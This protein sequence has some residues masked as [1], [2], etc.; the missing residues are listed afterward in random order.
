MILKFISRYKHF[1]LA[2]ALSFLTYLVFYGQFLNS[3][4]YFWGSDA[5][6]EYVPAR[7]YLYDKIVN[8]HAF[9]FWTEKMY[10]GFPIYADLENSYLNPVNVAAILI[11]GPH[12]SYRVLHLLEYLVGSLSL[13]YLLKRKGIGILGYFV[14]NLIFYFNTFSIDHQIH[15]NIIMAFYLIPTTFL[16]ADLFLEK[17]RLRYIILQSLVIANAVLWGHMQSAVIV[18]LGVF[19]YMLVF[20]FKKI[21]FSTFLFYFIILIFLIVIETLPQVLPTFELFNQSI[22]KESLDYLKGSLNPRMAIFSFVPY[23][24][25]GYKHFV[26]KEIYNGFTYTEI[27]TYIGISSVM[28]S[29]LALLL[30]KKTRD[31]ILAVVFIWIFLILGFLTYNGIFPH[32]TPILTLFR[33]WERTFVLASFGIALLVGIL[34]ERIK[35]VSLRYMPVG[36]L[37]VLSLPAYMWLLIKIGKQ[38]RISRRLDIYINSRYL[39]EVYPYFTVLRNILLVT[40]AIF[41]IFIAIKKFFPLISSKILPFI[42]VAFIGVIFFDLLYFSKDV[43]AFRLQ[44]IADYKIGSAPTE[45]VNKRIILRSGN[46]NGMESLYYD[47]W[48]PFGY[49]QLKEDDY[50]SFGNKLGIGDSLKANFNSLPKDRKKLTEMGVVATASSDEINYLTDNQLDILKNNIDGQYIKKEEGHISMKINNPENTMIGTYLKYSPYWIVK[51]DGKETQ[52]TKSGVFFDFSLS[53][54]NHLIEIDYYPKPFFIGILLSITLL[55]GFML[56]YYFFKKQLY[57]HVLK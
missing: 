56:S 17:K 37:F 30:L 14:S 47:N 7:V 50:I 28:L 31:I 42:K 19:L 55:I 8:E 45:L 54:G 40:L 11:F 52:I 49:S 15:F 39:Q 12:L 18:F 3:E 53:K 23:V 4:H 20:F 27:Y 41:L 44:N 25:G 26:G 16:L 6:I 36:L 34:I 5:T 29:T 22:R 57:N 43:L 2:I 1:L 46:I 35:D 21:R 10:S 33:D 38:S 51:I 48:S 13:Y 32:N 9:P 24:L